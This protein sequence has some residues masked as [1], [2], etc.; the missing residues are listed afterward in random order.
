MIREAATDADTVAYAA[1]WSAVRP[2]DPISADFVRGRLEREPERLY[3]LAERDGH[4]VACGV[5]IPSS[6]PDRGY[7]C[8][9]V[10]PESRRR[11]LGSALLEGCLGHAR[12]LELTEVTTTVVEGDGE[13]LRFSERR[14]FVE[15]ERSVELALELRGDEQPLVPPPGIEIAELSDGLHESAYE[16]FADGVADIPSAEPLHVPPFERWLDKAS[17]SPLTL[18]ALDGHRVVGLAELEIRHPEAGLLGN[19]LTTVRRSHRR[20]GIAE[21]LKRH[22]IAWAA[23]HGYRRLVTSN[24]ETNEPMRALNEKLG[25]RP[26]PALIGLRRRLD[27]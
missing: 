6:T 4:A 17:T 21:A 8:V 11:G 15:F 7:V 20:R 23:A 22:Q 10:L 14:G 1:I 26:L 3:L 9:T 12:E 24:D 13:A 2:Q 25:Y 5:T 18:V 16:T 27:A 19:Q